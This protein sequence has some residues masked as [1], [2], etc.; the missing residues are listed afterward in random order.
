[1]RRPKPWKILNSNGTMTKQSVISKSMVS[2]LMKEQLSSTTLGLLRYLTPDHSREEERY[3]SI[4]KSVQ[5]RLLVVVHTE[6]EERFRLIS[7]RRAT[8]AERK[9]YETNE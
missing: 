8:S 1:M 9:F 2:A 7:C 5:G 4:G 3:I 6:R